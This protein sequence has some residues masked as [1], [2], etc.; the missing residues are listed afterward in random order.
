MKIYDVEILSIGPQVDG[1]FR[2]K[3]GKQFDWLYEKCRFMREKWASAL[4]RI[5][6]GKLFRLTKKKRKALQFSVG[7]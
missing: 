6:H 5:F 4:F 7:N 1:D 2:R 3:A